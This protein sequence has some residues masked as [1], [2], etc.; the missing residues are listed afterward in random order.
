MGAGVARASGYGRIAD[1]A[2]TAD[3][4]VCLIVQAESR[5]AVENIDQIAAVEGVD[6]VFVGPADLSADL[7]RPGE[8]RHPEVLKAASHIVERTRAVGKAAGTI[9][10][11]AAEIEAA[12]ADGVTF[13]GVGADAVLLQEALAIR[14]EA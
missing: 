3:G 4:Q 6:G 8:T 1:Y 9:W 14:A 10:F 13:I 12:L 7:G 2:E 11:E 5:A